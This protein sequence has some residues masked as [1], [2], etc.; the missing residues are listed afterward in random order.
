MS[1]T[2]S[3][4][5]NKT[6]DNGEKGELKGFAKFL[7]FLKSYFSKPSNIILIIFAI[8]LT[9]TVVIPLVFLLYNT[10]L[11]HQGEARRL[12]VA[13]GSLTLNHWYSIFFQSK[14]N[15]AVTTFYKPLVNSV[16]MAL[17]ACLISLIIGGGIAW[18]I[19]RSDFPAKK[20]ISTVFVFPYIMPSWSIAMFWE[21]FFKNNVN[22]VGAQAQ[23]GML[24]SLTRI[25]VP[26]GMVYGF[27]P[28]AICLGIHYAPFAY[29]LIGGI[30]RNMDANLEEAA[31]ILKATRFKILRRITLP[32]V[33]P[34][35]LST[36]LL[37]FASSVSSYT[38][39]AFLGIKSGFMTLSLQMKSLINGSQ[40]KGQGYVMATVLMLF[41]ILILMVN[42]FVTNSRRS[43]TTVTGKSSQVSLVKLGKV[44]KPI[45]TTI[46][47]FYAAFFAIIPLISFAL[48]SF[49]EVSG[50]YST[51]TL[52]Y[53]ITSEQTNAYITGSV[54]IFRN[55]EIWRAFGN[56][57][58][59]SIICALIA[60]TFGILVGYGVAKKRGSRLA[61]YVSNLAFLPYLIPAMSFATIYLIMSYTK[62]LS[63][64]NGS[65]LLLIVVGSIKFLPFASKSGTNAMLQ[66]SNEIE[67]AAIIVG[68]PWWK[69]MVR[70]LF[71]IQ[72]SSFISGYLLP[73]VSCMRELTLFVLLTGSS[74]ILTAVLQ[75]YEKYD[76]VQISNG[77]NLIIIVSVLVIN[78]VVNKLTGA[79]IDKGVGG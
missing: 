24:Q 52:Y 56:S 22:L 5:E 67:E 12:G 39:P 45:I 28:C 36:V 15:Y 54:G 25:A 32:I 37:V 29:I 10:V 13:V 23:M 68:V 34:A 30:L 79:S 2:I 16:G 62:A 53:W 66:L 35:L 8:L 38:V 61:N 18:L 69:R 7:N 64:L 27:W 65:L 41:S 55:K 14:Y 4:N 49:L 72:K 47:V 51:F 19:T 3:I 44:G 43:F 17:V 75:N 40:Y 63:F 33:M 77:I 57:L 59:I 1:D 6:P 20:F 48:E 21:N 11:V 46:V 60:G 9:L 31:T 74:T 42:Q 58:L 70:V 78:L 76:C 50:D 71:P 73:F 26:G